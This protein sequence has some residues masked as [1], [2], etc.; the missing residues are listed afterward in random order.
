[1]DTKGLRVEIKDADRGEITAVFATFNT[2]DSDGDV[3]LPGAFDD[4]APVRISAYNHTSW[5]GALPVGK[6]VIRQTA[7]EA[8]LDGQFFMGLPHAAD[9][10]AMVRE[11]GEL[12]E[13]SYGYDPLK[14]SFGEFGDPP[15]RVRFL[16][17]QKVYEVSPVLLGAG[18]NT[19]TLA[20]K[21][22]LTF[23]GEAQAVLAAVTVLA[24]RAADVLAKRREKG[25]G[26]GDESA[27]LLGRI[28]AQLK[29][30]TEVLQA[31]APETD[32]GDLEREYLR[33]VALT[34]TARSA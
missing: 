6:G 16:E 5:G 15:K 32:T 22:G 30:L 18:V 2:M 25:K 23:A 9:T 14:Y 8:I 27:D 7:T 4:G 19:R 3:T 10:F 21:S 28:D 20:A 11:M 13:Y 24:D 17:K 1:M 26:L 12:Q 31:P 29:R 34:R 33:F